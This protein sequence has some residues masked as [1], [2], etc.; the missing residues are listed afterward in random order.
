MMGPETPF[1]TNIPEDPR[2]SEVAEQLYGD[3]VFFI[4]SDANRYVGNTSWHPGP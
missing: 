4:V 3:D 1:F 2:F